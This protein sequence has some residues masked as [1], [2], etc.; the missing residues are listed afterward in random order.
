MT[1]DLSGLDIPAVQIDRV[2]IA[3][4]LVLVAA[5][6]IAGSVALAGRSPC[7][8]PLR[9]RRADEVAGRPL[10]ALMCAGPAN[11]LVMTRVRPDLGQSDECSRAILFDVLVKRP[12]WP[13]RNRWAT[14]AVGLAERRYPDGAAG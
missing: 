5:I 11:P 3:E 13:V 2:D 6:G 10:I 9:S 4:H 14:L 12:K 8:A 1:S 7:A